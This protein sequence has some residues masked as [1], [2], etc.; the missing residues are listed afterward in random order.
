MLAV[1]SS[2]LASLSPDLSLIS[3]N[4]EPREL[5]E[6]RPIVADV[7]FESLMSKADKRSA[8][9]S[10][11]R[12]SRASRGTPSSRNQTTGN[13]IEFVD[14]Q[15]P[16]VKSAIQRH[17]AYHSAA[18]RREARLQSLRQGGQSRYLEWGRRHGTSSAPVASSEDSASSSSYSLVPD[19]R[20]QSSGSS[21]TNL[22]AANTPEARPQTL[23]RETSGESTASTLTP[24]EETVLQFCRFYLRVQHQLSSD[25]RASIEAL[26]SLILSADSLELTTTGVDRLSREHPEPP[27]EIIIAFMRTDEACTQLLLA[28][29][30]QLRAKLAASESTEESDGRAAQQ[31]LGRGT[32]LLWNRLRDPDT[33]SSDANIQAVLLLVSYTFDFGP[34]DEVELHADALR[35]MVQQRGGL[36]ALE[37]NAALH[38]QLTAADSAR[39]YHLTLDCPDDD[40]GRDRRYPEGFWIKTDDLR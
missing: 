26:R 25:D 7:G 21:R 18:Q 4:P 39:R 34:R 33:A 31:H 35:T 36:D 9:E 29:C 27:Y 1:N 16:N 13:I 30:Y 32:N 3:H 12:S 37:S 5:F 2:T 19:A 6:W 38:R 23:S 10:P 24:V 40:C 28:Y 22:L 20:L 15:D 11:T 8:E 17:T 14:S